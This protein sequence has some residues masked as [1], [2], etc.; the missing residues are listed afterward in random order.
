MRVGKVVMNVK[1]RKKKVYTKMNK[2]GS[3]R[4]EL[5][6][7]TAATTDPSPLKYSHGVSYREE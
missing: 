6:A 1:K 7:T 4:D 5:E 3:K 2:N